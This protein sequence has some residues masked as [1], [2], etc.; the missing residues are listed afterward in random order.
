MSTFRFNNTPHKLGMQIWGDRLSFHKLHEMV[1]QCWD[2]GAIEMTRAQECSYIGV[3]GYFSYTIRH[4][5]M[6]HRLVKLD[7]KPLKS[8]RDEVFELFERESDRF[9]VGM[10]FSWPQMLFIMAAWWECLKHRECPAG[11]LPI[12]LEFTQNIEHLLQER[13][14]LQY[15]SIEPYI[16]GAIYAANPYLM[17]TMEHINVPY[18]RKSRYSRV[19]LTTLA[20]LMQ[21]S[22]YGTW[23]Y[24]YHLDNLRKNAK[25]L[26]C[27]IEDLEE[28]VDESVYDTAL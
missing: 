16:H 24:N 25:R 11:V 8:W 20:E 6:G 26:G 15:P 21:C 12:M 27:G 13:S 5:F 17:H 9:E 28:R 1:G 10:E 4:A 2:C 23:D 22:A 7:G 3:V 18:L 14:K 19:S